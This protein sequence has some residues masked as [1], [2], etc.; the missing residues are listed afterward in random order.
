MAGI[1]STNKGSVYFAFLGHDFSSDEALDIEI[2]R[3][4][5]LK[6]VLNFYPTKNSFLTLDDYQVFL[7]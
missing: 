5:M 1:A 6:S 2:A 3:D 4:K 7:K